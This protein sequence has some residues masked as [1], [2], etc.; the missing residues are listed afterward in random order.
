MSNDNGKGK[1]RSQVG[2]K[3][4]SNAQKR[5]GKKTWRRGKKNVFSD[6]VRRGREEKL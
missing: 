5:E 6:G 2:K 4:A 3:K 1:A